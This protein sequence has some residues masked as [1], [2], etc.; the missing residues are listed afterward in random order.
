MF[1]LNCKSTIR[2]QWLRFH[3]LGEGIVFCGLNVFC[4]SHWNS[5]Y[6]SLWPTKRASHTVWVLCYQTSVG[7][8]VKQRQDLWLPEMFYLILRFHRYTVSELVLDLFS[9]PLRT[10]LLLSSVYFTRGTLIF[11]CIW[12]LYC[13]LIYIREWRKAGSPNFQA[14][15]SQSLLD[16]VALPGSW[17]WSQ[18]MGVRECRLVGRYIL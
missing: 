5:D 10:C 4:R 6:L 13:G 12:K 7:L 11:C 8:P 18:S 2:N 3:V 1:N 15:F 17:L 14:S 9:L 16:K